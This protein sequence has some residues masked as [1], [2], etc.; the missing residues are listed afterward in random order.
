M[1]GFNC[2]RK[3]K[4]SISN[5]CKTMD[6][7]TVKFFWWGSCNATGLLECSLLVS[8]L[9]NRNAMNIIESMSMHVYILRGIT[10]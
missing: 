5:N 7:R 3:S 10:Y 2:T 1:D 6:K 9:C 4:M 8:T